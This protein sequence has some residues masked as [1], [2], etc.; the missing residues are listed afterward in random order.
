VQRDFL[1]LEDYKELLATPDWRVSV[2]RLVRS[3]RQGSLVFKALSVGLLFVHRSLL[4]V[5]FSIRV[6]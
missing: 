6:A 1:V 3:V 4:L 5:P 2:D